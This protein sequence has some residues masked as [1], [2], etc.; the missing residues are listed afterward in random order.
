MIELIE[1]FARTSGIYGFMTSRWGWPFIESLHFLGLCL[2]MSAVILFDLRVLGVAKGIPV[3]A[4]HTMIPF[5]VAGF[6]LNLCTGF[7]FFVSAP[8]QYAFNPAFQTKMFFILLAGL[9]MLLFYGFAHVTVKDDSVARL[10]SRALVMVSVSL[11][12]WTMVIICGRLITFFRPPYF[13][14]IWC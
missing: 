7:L 1:Y 4:L 6:V 3:A 8:D 14:C 12:C 2:L 5:G 11:L 13:W 9:N 10:P